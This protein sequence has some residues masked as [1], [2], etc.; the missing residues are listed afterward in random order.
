[1]TKLD[2]IRETWMCAP[3]TRAVMGALDAGHGAARFVG[4]AVR[5]ALLGRQVEDIDIATTLRPDDVVRR[6]EAAGIKAL[7]TG[8]A[9]GT[10]TA[11]FTGKTFEVTTLRRDVTT[12]GRHAAVAF[13]DDWKLDAQRRDFTINA[14][15][16]S[17]DGEVFDYTSGVEDLK[18]RRIRFIGDPV[19][20]IREDYLR[21]LRLFRFH[22]W[23][24]RGDI[25]T[26]ALAAVRNERAGLR[27]LSGERVRNEFL[28]LL[29]ADDP[30]PAVRAMAEA[31]I[32]RE[33][34]PGEA[35]LAR[36]GHLVLIDTGNRFIGDP[37]LR[38]SALIAG[39]AAIATAVAQRLRLSNDN[40]NRI[41][42]VASSEN[43]PAFPMDVRALRAL[44]YR[45]GAQ[46]VRDR[47][48][49]RW[50]GE[51]TDAH[52]VEW[53]ALLAVVNVWMPPR[54][55]LSGGDVITAKIPEGPRVGKVLGEL[56][57]WWIAND[58]APDRAALLERLNAIAPGHID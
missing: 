34:L 6:L 31:D 1:M 11:V 22:A 47:I 48:L 9:H 51:P 41:V 38:L 35:R 58:F 45:L 39:D 50:A 27:R 18:A 10:V 15:S 28:R 33:F 46:R 30:C 42:D 36:L 32:V 43:E 40:R 21:I 25:D 54:F 19:A 13:S 26:D 16:A 4:G 20:R 2:P 17:P 5:N 29:A 37:V 7:P 52:A 3:E 12:D 14:L 24:G 57:N 56:E 23:Y 49:L 44:L 55:P 53:R 8:M